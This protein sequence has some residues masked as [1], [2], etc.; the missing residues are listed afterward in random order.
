MFAELYAEH[1][2]QVP[3]IQSYIFLKLLILE[4]M[5]ISPPSK[6]FDIFNFTQMHRNFDKHYDLRI[7]SHIIAA[8]SHGIKCR[9]KYQ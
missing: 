6:W 5:S 4:S 7:F 8:L 9:L 1:K 3:P 2:S